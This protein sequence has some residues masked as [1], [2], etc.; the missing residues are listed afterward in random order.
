M[1]SA[2]RIACFSSRTMVSCSR[3]PILPLVALLFLAGWVPASAQQIQVSPDADTVFSFSGFE[4]GPFAPETITD[5]KLDN[6]DVRDAAFTVVTNQIWLEVAPSEGNVGGLF[7]RNISVEATLNNAEATDLAPG[8]YTA[9]VSFKNLTNG[10]GDTQRIVRLNVAP[11]NFSVA[12]AFVHATATLNGP[13][14]PGVAVILHGNGQPALNYELEWTAK[15]W[16]SVD[17]NGGTV[18]GSGSSTFNVSFHIAGLEAGTYTSQIDI[19]NTTNG[20]GS[21]QIPVSLTVKSK[22]AGGMILLPDQDIEVRGPVGELPA[23]I[24]QSSIVNDGEESVDWNAV[25][26]FPWVSVTPSAGQLAASD[27][28]SGGL[29]ERNITIRINSA[30]QTIPAGSS[31]ATVT[32]QKTFVNPINGTTTGV[33]FGTRVVHFV[34]DPVLGLSMPA[35]GGSIATDPP[36]MA[37]DLATSTSKRLSY[38]FGEVVVVT[39]TPG[40]GYEFRG[41]AGDYPEDAQTTNPIILPM[42]AS[43]NLGALIAPILRDLSLGVVGNGS[44]TI[45]MAPTGVEIE[46]SLSASYTN[47]TNVTLTADADAGSVFRGWGGNVPPG[48]ELLNPLTIM[49]D[50][51][52][53][54]SARFEPAITLEVSEG[55]GG[56]VSVNPDLRAFAAGMTVILTA[57]PDESFVFSGWSGDA[58]GT[59]N[60]LTITLGGDTSISASFVPDTDSGGGEGGGDGGGGGDNNTAKLFVD[61]QGDGVVT[62][63]GGTYVKGATVTVIATPGLNSTFVHWEQAATGTELVTTIVMDSDLTVRAV[64]EPIDNSGGRP[65]PDGSGSGTIPACGAMG[66]LGLPMMLF[67]WASLASLSRRR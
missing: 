63:S 7:T 59:D 27:G 2:P 56:S 57:T 46:N 14:P 53:V 51:E 45:D 17:R 11:A 42:D 47:G 54:I 39:A 1:F 5:W 33:A 16:F 44:G 40:D 10:D 22:G 36:G 12:P 38:G 4:G 61:I 15:P 48:E 8:V 3:F 32:F 34:A 52:R 43:K 9:V 37:V 30:A 35:V 24:Q 60:P 26:D 29:D 20:A 66:F 41:W 49:M 25:I 31:I 58:G 19:T 62:P 50:R 23:I 55:D 6:S 65:N 21:R 13:N 18:P 67:C 28:V 64:F